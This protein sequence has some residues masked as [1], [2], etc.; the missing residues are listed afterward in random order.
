MT[1]GSY[2]VGAPLTPPRAKPS[3][4]RS[5]RP[6][7]G[8]SPDIPPPTRGKLPGAAATFPAGAV[9]QGGVTAGLIA[10]GVIGTGYEAYRTD[11][12]QMARFSAEQSVRYLSEF[13][14]RQGW[15]GSD[16]VR[17]ARIAY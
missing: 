13:F 17:K 16:Q 9:V 3:T 12:V 14:A 10:G 15:I 11:V 2:I 6:I 5:T 4:I 1:L 8:R 7:R